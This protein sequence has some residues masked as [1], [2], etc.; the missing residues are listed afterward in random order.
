MADYEKLLQVPRATK[1]RLETIKLD[2]LPN[3]LVFATDTKELGVK[4]S[5]GNIEYFKNATDINAIVNNLETSKQDK[6]VAGDNI[7]IEN[8]V[9]SASGSG[10]G[11]TRTTVNIP[12]TE[13]ITQTQTTIIVAYSYVGDDP[14]NYTGDFSNFTLGGDLVLEMPG[15]GEVPI[16]MVVQQAF[17]K[18]TLNYFE[19]IILFRYIITA[20]LY[21]AINN[22]VGHDN[23]RNDVF[24][25]YDIDYVSLSSN[26]FKGVS[27]LDMNGAQFIVDFMMA[28]E[29]I[30]FYNTLTGRGSDLSVSVETI[31]EISSSPI[32]TEVYAGYVNDEFFESRWHELITEN[33]LSYSNQN[34]YYNHI[35]GMTLKFSPYIKM[36]PNFNG[37][38]FGPVY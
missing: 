1:A 16:S 29:D 15:I 8:N 11:I 33:E 36:K 12:F 32:I 19:I 27:G 35:G 26:V 34:L 10:G 7:T 20:T 38:H 21:G 4:L 23:S 2:L 6:L 30:P 9:I 37:S 14:V 25:T 17:G 3:T 24:R 18:T 13:V 22:G 31:G 28:C 5:N